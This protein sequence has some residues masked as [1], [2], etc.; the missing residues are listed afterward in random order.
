MIVVLLTLVVI[1]C[2][3]VSLPGFSMI[4]TQFVVGCGK[5]KSCASKKANTMQSLDKHLRTIN[6]SVGSF[7]VVFPEHWALQM[8]FG[9]SFVIL[10][11]N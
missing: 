5:F 2:N 4:L 7:V 11:T 10:S 9:K 3:C 6:H 8:C 1:D